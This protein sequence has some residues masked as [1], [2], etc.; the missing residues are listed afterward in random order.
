MIWELFFTDKSGYRPTRTRK[1]FPD[2]TRPVPADTGR[3]GYTRRPLLPTLYTFHRLTNR[4]SVR[5]AYL[6]STVKDEPIEMPPGCK[7]DRVLLDKVLAYSAPKLS[8]WI[9]FKGMGK[10]AWTECV[11]QK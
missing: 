4:H 10:G 5:L 8:R 9:Y 6:S 2:P 1:A 7:I 11:K 3:V